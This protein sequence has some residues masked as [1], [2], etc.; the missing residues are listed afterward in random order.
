VTKTS[1]TS[2]VSPPCRPFLRWAGSKRSVLPHLKQFV[3]SDYRRYIE[4]F[5]GSAC[6]FFD[7]EPAR[8]VL[9][10]LNQ[11]LIQTFATVRESPKRVAS[12]L[13]RMEKGEKA[14]YR[15]RAE[16]PARLSQ[17]RRAARFI[18]LN[19]FCFNG[20]YRTNI[21]GGFN[22]PFGRP[23]SASVPGADDLGRCA[24]LLKRTALVAGD[25]EAV[26]KEF[27]K[28]GDLVYLDPPFFQRK[29]RMFR[30]Y[31]A[32]PF[33]DCDLKRLGALLKFLDRLGATFIVSYAFCPEALATFAAWPKYRIRTQRNISGFADHRKI[34]TEL[35][36]SNSTA[37]PGLHAG[38]A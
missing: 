28:S 18:Y 33:S 13:A 16:N 9:G 2:R 19:R 17:L 5:A 7:L 26:V 36:F 11:D 6:F 38:H 1:C 31:T 21:R 30:Q 35:V 22:V 8:A 34:A 10:D 25:F 29:R 23:K 20:L 37:R 24:D 3:P 32:H 14:Y 12:L 4:P 27:V 15:I